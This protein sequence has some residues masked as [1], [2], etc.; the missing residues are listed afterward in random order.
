[1]ASNSGEQ[2][3]KLHCGRGRWRSVG[4]DRMKAKYLRL[5]YNLYTSFNSHPS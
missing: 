3:L 5:C 1:M 2:C 4:G